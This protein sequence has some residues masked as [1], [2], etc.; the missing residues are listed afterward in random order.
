VLNGGAGNDVFR[1][2]TTAAANGDTVLGFEPGDRLDLS[3]I[4]ANLGSSGDQAFQI[5]SGGGFTAAGQ[6]AFSFV[7]N[8]DGDF[9]VIQGNVDGDTGADFQIQVEGHHAISSA[10]TTL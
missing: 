4:D 10:N 2:N 7:S 3:T 5:I 8:D 9:T 1:F 6:L